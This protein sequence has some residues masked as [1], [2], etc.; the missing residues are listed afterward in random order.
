MLYS[1]GVFINRC[2]DELNLSQPDLVC[3]IHK[4]YLDAGAQ[5]IETN[6][7]G[8]NRSKLTPHGLDGKLEEM[9][10]EAVRLAKRAV[11]ESRRDAF[12]AGAV[13]PLGSPLQRTDAPKPD[14]MQEIFSEQIVTLADAGVDCILI[15]TISHL[16]EMRRAIRAA[17]EGTD[18]PVLAQMTFTEEGT[19]IFGDRPEEVA[20]LLLAEGADLVGV[21]CSIGPKPMLTVLERLSTAGDFLLSAQPNAGS[22]Q[23]VEGRYMYF[24]SPEYMATYAHQFIRQTGVNLIGGCC[25][26]TP[27]HI[28]AVAAAVR[29]LQPTRIETSV[30]TQKEEQAPEVTPVEAGDKSRFARRLFSGKFVTSVE[31][32]P[33]RGTGIKKVVAGARAVQAAGVDAV[34]IPDGPRAS[35][36]MSPLSLGAM[37]AREAEI[38]VLLH[39]CCRDRNLLGMQSDLLGAHVLGLRNLLVVTGDPPKLGDYPSATA[40]FDVDSIGL[41]RIVNKLNHGRDLADN[42]IG[43]PTSFLIGV[44]VNPGAPNLDEEIERLKEKVDAG[45]EYIMTQPVF[46]AGRLHEFLRRV[47]E[48]TLPIVVGILPLTSYRNAEFYHNEVPGMNIPDGVRERM[49][50][51]GSGETARREGIAIARHALEGSAELPEVKGVY[52]MPPFGRYEMAIEVLDR[53]IDRTDDDQ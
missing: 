23:R 8:A 13:G 41:T 9:N 45:A 12:V 16:D 26:T 47:E 43:Q 18:L 36:R 33:P 28:R 14:E 3:E 6:S 25:G 37:L 50:K 34:N 5:V 4:A 1:H 42:S 31:V 30:V 46:D 53:F 7:Y 21:N 10:R 15:E 17:R 19:T 49:R 22:P 11:T 27:E 29:S 35:A 52:V 24:C 44:G 20:P 39:Y 38:D 32:N 48:V 2:Y 51:A 40:V